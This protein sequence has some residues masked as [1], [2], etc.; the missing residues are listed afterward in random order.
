MRMSNVNDDEL[1]ELNDSTKPIEKN[2]LNDDQLIQKANNP[3]SND[4]P[5]MSEISPPIME[6]HMDNSNYYSIEGLPSRYRLYKSGTKITGRPLKVIE[7]KKLSSLMEGNAD[8][9]VNDIL[10]RTIRGINV[11]DILVADK[12]FL[13]LWLRANTYRDS[14]YVVDFTCSKC[15]Q[16][17]QYHF[18]LNNLDVQELSDEYIP[19]NEITLKSGNR[20]NIRFLTIGDELK[21][22]RF[23]EMNLKSVGEIDD[24]LLNI[25]MML[26][27]LNNPNMSMIEKYYWVMNMEPGDFTY[28]ASYIQKY[29]MGI[30]PYVNVKCDNCGGTGP[31]GISFRSDFFLPNYKFE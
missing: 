9:I 30:K 17:S 5:L 23:K 14:G 13:I 25:S 6:T 7:V 31:V 19:D 18:D 8:Y 29:G 11:E 3:I 22:S 27:D 20:V 26:T 15:D 4:R 12:L 24:D 1:K 10:R 16:D 28:I 21:R 2:E